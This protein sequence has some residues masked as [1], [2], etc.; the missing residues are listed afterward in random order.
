MC[1]N[2]ELKSKIVEL[3]KKLKVIDDFFAILSHCARNRNN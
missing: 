3:E 2:E 1:E